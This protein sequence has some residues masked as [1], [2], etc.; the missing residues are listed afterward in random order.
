MRFGVIIYGPTA[1]GKTDFANLLAAQFPSEIINADAAQFYTPLTLGTAKTDWRQASFPHHMFDICN[2]PINYSVANYRT[3]SEKLVT[4]IAKRGNIPIFVGGSGF[5][6]HSLFF[7]I[8]V[9]SVPLTTQLESDR[10]WEALYAIDPVRAKAIHPNDMYRIS[11]ALLLYQQTNRLPSDFKPTYC[12]ITQFIF[13]ELSC[14]PDLLQQ[15]IQKRISQ[16]IEQGWV[17]ETETLLGT[18]WEPFIAK[19]KW[20]GYAELVAYC[21]TGKKL[22]HIEEI[23]NAINR[24][25]W[26]YAR[27]QTAYARM[28]RQKIV[29]ADKHAYYVK[30]DLTSHSLELYI[31]QLAEHILLLQ[32]GFSNE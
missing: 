7:P 2:K 6:V 9:Q 18:A 3:D 5:Y 12:P 10:S 26:R 15:R 25:T 14:A 21:Y 11:R 19:K 29:Q 23:K 13:I 32:K 1:V 8:N 4:S 27:K 17:R 30:I 22:D 16:M 28:L 24:T 31:K 20:I